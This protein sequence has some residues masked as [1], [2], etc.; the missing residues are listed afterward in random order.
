MHRLNYL[1]CTQIQMFG[2]SKVLVCNLKFF[3]QSLYFENTCKEKEMQSFDWKIAN[4]VHMSDDWYCEV[5][6]YAVS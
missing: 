4:T 2:E 5:P 6:Y 3:V 1:D